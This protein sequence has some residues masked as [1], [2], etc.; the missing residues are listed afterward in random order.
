MQGEGLFG[1][2]LDFIFTKI[3]SLQSIYVYTCCWPSKKAGFIK[4]VEEFCLDLIIN[5]NKL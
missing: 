2:L 1:I 4:G 3:R 5:L